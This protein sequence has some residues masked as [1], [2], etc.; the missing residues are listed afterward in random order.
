[1]K[2]AWRIV[3]SDA[4]LAGRDIV[5]LYGKRFSIEEMFR[6]MKDLRYGMGMSWNQVGT[7]DRR[8]RMFLIA[9]I[10]HGLLTLLGAAGESLGLDRLLKSNT[11]KKRTL[12]LFRQGL[13][14]YERIPMMPVERLRPLMRRFGEMMIVET[15]YASMFGGV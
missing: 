1:M 9:A 10:A 11:A 6:D 5:A 3:A 15:I 14:W 2:D 8:D 7:P 4:S 12:S 13:M